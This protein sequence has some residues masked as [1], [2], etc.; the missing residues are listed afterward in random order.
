MYYLIRN[1]NKHLSG[2]LFLSSVLL[3]GY[4]YFYINNSALFDFGDEGYIYYLGWSMLE[5][6]LPYHDF[7]IDS[8][9][10][11][12]F[13][14]YALFFKGLGVSIDIARIA[15][16]LLM[17]VNIWLCYCFVKKTA[18][19]GLALLAAFIIGF[20]P[21]PWIKAC[22][23]TLC[24]ASIFLA[25]RIQSR[26]SI[27]D[28]VL[29]GVVIALGLQFR[30]DAVVCA[31]T[32]LILGVWGKTLNRQLIYHIGALILSGCIA[33]LPLLA[34]LG[35]NNLVTEYLF[36]LTNYFNLVLERTSA[37]Y[38]MPAPSLDQIMTEGV[39]GFPTLFF[40]S[41]LVI[42]ILFI[43]LIFKSIE[44]CENKD[45]IVRVSL[46]LAVWLA[47]STPQ[48]ALERPD[49]YHFFQ[50][51]FALI[52][53][54]LFLLGK[55]GLSSLHNFR[56]VKPFQVALILFLLLYG[57]NGIRSDASGSLGLRLSQ[58]EP[59]HLSTGI[60]FKEPPDSPLRKIAIKIDQL[61]NQTDRLAA[62]PYLPGLNFVLQ[63]HTPGKK[64]H[65]FPNKIRSKEEDFSAAAEISQANFILLLPYFQLSPNPKAALGCYAPLL[66]REINT[67]FISLVNYNHLRLLQS[68]K[69]TMNVDMI[70]PKCP[71]FKKETDAI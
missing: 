44:R 67:K 65:Y 12:V 26:N 48:Y 4:Y 20:I 13:L 37:W 58:I 46:L 57:V 64:V 21:G 68:G 2:I 16:V 14:Y 22:I 41:F 17:F 55:N 70:I 19:S 9:P 23:T 56:F 52:V 47:L 66:S 45:T 8:Y 69:T 1:S 42:T 25:V 34:Y 36:Q 28:Y 43:F 61:S 53:C 32:L 15:S 54:A 60:V 30:I 39:L 27:R 40:S 62:V 59:V 49:P 63:L 18:G 6:R 35:I 51:G 50:R 24:L 5:G 29:M 11:G 38:K 7:Q 3:F 33:M 71:N 31:V 10:P